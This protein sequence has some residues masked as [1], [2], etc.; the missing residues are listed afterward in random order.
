MQVRI[1]L[2]SNSPRNPDSENSIAQFTTSLAAAE[3]M[4]ENQEGGITL[5]IHDLTPCAVFDRIPRNACRQPATT[6]AHAKP[7]PHKNTRL[8]EYENYAVPN[9]STG[10]LSRLENMTE[11]LFEVSGGIV[12]THRITS[13]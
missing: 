3:I 1:G 10:C 4:I 6:A 12:S 2:L 5:L 9:H 7:H 11:A 13:A 8:H